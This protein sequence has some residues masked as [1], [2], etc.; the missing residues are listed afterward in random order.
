MNGKGTKRAK[1]EAM[2]A[3]KLAED[4]DGHGTATQQAMQV[5]RCRLSARIKTCPLHP[6]RRANEA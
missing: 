4:G 3:A 1:H 5:R 2:R 6:L